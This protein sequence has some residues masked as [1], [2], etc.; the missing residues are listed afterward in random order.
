MNAQV[1]SLKFRDVEVGRRLVDRLQSVTDEI[2]R[3]DITVMHVCGS[4]EQAMGRF[5]LRAAFPKALNVVMG[6]GCPVCITDGPEVD[7]AVALAMQGVR[8]ATYGDM[9]RVPGT[10][11]S[12]ADARAEGAKVDVVYGVAQAVE[13]A[14]STS[15][16]VVFFAT[17]FETTAVA[18]AAMVLRGVPDNFSILSAHKYIPPAMEV[19]ASMPDTAVEG[20]LAAGHAATVTGY[21]IF[22]PFAER[23]R[24]PVVVTG[25]E[26]L[27]I[28]AGLTR[29]V[30]MIRDGEH[31]VVNAF[32]R[33]VDAE[34][35]R[36]AMD[37]LWRVFG[38]GGGQWRGIASVDEGNLEL[39]P[40]FDHVNARK[41]FDIDTTLLQRE[42][43]AL[44]DLA[45][46][47]QCGGIMAGRAQPTDCPLYGKACTPA[48]P[49]GACMVSTEGM[50]RIWS[51][52]GGRP[53]LSE[54][55]S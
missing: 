33:C 8:V 30:T 17:G 16:P 5:G 28:L 36:A 15:E 23:H 35:N 38:A 51:E 54:S 20:Y 3:S 37:A 24:V 52:Y 19:V 14:E 4:H 21:R 7:E 53:D 45:A 13:I 31:G 10:V 32:P 44:G 29:I 1:Q 11:K 39:L 40:A 55:A 2:G 9:L 49:V 18:T 46:Q 41:R 34:G 22:E 43:S 47:C 27:D 25:F 12:L 50:C 48:E 6:P 26:P 42:T